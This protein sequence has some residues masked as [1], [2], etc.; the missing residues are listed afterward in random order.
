MTDIPDYIEAR[1]RQHPPTA[2]FVIAGS[3]PVVAFGDVRK[4]VVATLG[5]NP[6]KREFH[7]RRGHELVGDKRRLETLA[8]IEVDDLETASFETVSRMFDSCNNYFHRNPF[9]GSKSLR[10]F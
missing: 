7:D 3:N 10:R 8:S 6:S 1:I 2:A 9:F 5:W 4:S